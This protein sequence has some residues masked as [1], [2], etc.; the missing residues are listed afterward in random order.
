M[1]EAARPTPAAYD[2]RVLDS[3]TSK[4]LAEYYKNPVRAARETASQALN[5][6]RSG[7]VK[8]G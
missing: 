2:Q 5:D 3:D 6:I 8:L 7:R 4:T 1:Q